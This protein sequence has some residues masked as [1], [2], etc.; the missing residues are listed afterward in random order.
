MLFGVADRAG[1]RG[2]LGVDRE[3]LLQ[4]L[5]G[6][7]L[8]AGTVADLALHVAQLVGVPEAGAA[9]LAV[10][11]DVT[12]DALVVVLLAALDQRAPRVSVHGLLP[13]RRRALVAAG[14]LGV[15]DEERTPRLGRRRRLR[16]LQVDRRDLRVEL[17]HLAG[18]LLVARQA[19]AQRDQPVREVVSLRGRRPGRIQLAA[20]REQALAFAPLAGD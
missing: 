12:A 19:P 9:D 15:A 18:D 5:L 11:G 20:L 1:A 10:A 6:D 3:R 14:A 16:A 7:V 8:R 17:A 13:E 4:P 2:C